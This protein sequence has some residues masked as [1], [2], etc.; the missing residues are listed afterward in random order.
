MGTKD[1]KS[2]AAL[3]D[4]PM[5]DITVT[6]A[7]GGPK[8][9]F[10][11]K[12]KPAESEEVVKGY[13]RKRVTKLSEPC[14]AALKTLSKSFTRPAGPLLLQGD[15]IPRHRTRRLVHCHGRSGGHCRL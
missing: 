6:E 4:K 9:K 10:S 3:L 5:E 8:M 14:S 2:F 13:Q 15:T 12:S 1:V 11:Q 7:I